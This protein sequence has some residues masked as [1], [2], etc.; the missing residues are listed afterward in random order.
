MRVAVTP[1]LQVASP[2]AGLSVQGLAAMLGIGVL[3]MMFFVPAALLSEFLM[4]RGGRAD[5]AEASWERS[6]K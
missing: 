4:R 6:W 3:T 1:S 2:D 5:S